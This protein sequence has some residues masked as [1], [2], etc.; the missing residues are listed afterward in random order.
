MTILE[1]LTEVQ[2]ESVGLKTMI[3]ADLNEANATYVDKLVK[4]EFP[5]LLVLPFAPTDTIGKSGA[6]K[7]TVDL[8]LF[9]LTTSKNPT[10]DYKSTEVETECIAP[11]RLL[12]RKFIHN[13]NHHSIIDPEGAGIV[14]Y[15]LTPAYSSMDANL[16]GVE[17]RVNVPVME[18]AQVCV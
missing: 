14:T 9:F 11:M 17:V 4:S 8:D 15:T 18:R 5:V 3:F 6:L 2:Q 1:A 16:Y 12:A 13:L 7:T 10:V